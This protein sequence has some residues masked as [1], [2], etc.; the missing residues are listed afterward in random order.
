MVANYDML[1]SLFEIFSYQLPIELHENA[2]YA[3]LNLISDC[4]NSIKEFI[5]N[6]PLKSPAKKQIN[7]G[8]LRHLISFLDDLY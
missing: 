7:R 1:M 5:I 4:S 3:L 2:L 8:G 6:Q